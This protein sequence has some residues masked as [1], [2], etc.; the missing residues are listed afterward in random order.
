MDLLATD[1]MLLHNSTLLF[2]QL[3]MLTIFASYFTLIFSI[4]MFILVSSS[5]TK[6]L[7]LQ[8]YHKTLLCTLA[9]FP[10]R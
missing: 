6:S 3:S 4:Q 9:V 7:K 2:L 10:R 8:I 1:I 5:E